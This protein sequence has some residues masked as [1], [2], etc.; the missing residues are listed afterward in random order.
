VSRLVLHDHEGKAA[1]SGRM[2]SRSRCLGFVSR[3][4]VFCAQAV[5]CPGLH[6]IALELHSIALEFCN[7]IESSH[8]CADVRSFRSRG[9]TTLMRFGPLDAGISL[10]LEG[11][12]FVIISTMHWHAH[13]QPANAAVL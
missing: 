8:G 9:N 1:F 12:S 11:P 10:L 6:S 13:R 7:V 5:Q 3:L 2:S 4:T